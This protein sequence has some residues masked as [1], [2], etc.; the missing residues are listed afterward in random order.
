M[1][2]R[3][4]KC[5]PLIGVGGRRK[6]SARPRNRARQSTFLRAPAS[7]RR[8]GPIVRPAGRPLEGGRRTRNKQASKQT[9]KQTNERAGQTKVS[10]RSFRAAP[11][12]PQCCPGTGLIIVDSR[13]LVHLSV[14]ASSGSITTRRSH[15]FA[16]VVFCLKIWPGRRRPLELAE[17]FPRPE[18]DDEMISAGR[19]GRLIGAQRSRLSRA[20]LGRRREELTMGEIIKIWRC[21]ALRCVALRCAAPRR[22]HLSPPV[23]LRVSH[24]ARLHP[25]RAVA[26]YNSFS[27][28]TQVARRSAGP[29]NSP[30]AL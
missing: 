24:V 30:A 2:A 5:G 22:A 1:R 23:S 11:G 3:T 18:L 19:R 4:D 28:R 25:R 9:N 12:G 27:A 17:R 29:Q 15:S 6:A 8:T 16:L 13:Q 10:R 7:S 21:V 14:G 26:K 20:D